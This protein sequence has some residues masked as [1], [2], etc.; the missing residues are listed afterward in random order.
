MEST[1]TKQLSSTQIIA[2][3]DALQKKSKNMKKSSKKRVANYFQAEE[4]KK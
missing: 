3:I 4:G 2:T 1:T